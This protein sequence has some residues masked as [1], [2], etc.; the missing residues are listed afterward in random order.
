[1]FDLFR[2]FSSLLE[3]V[4]AIGVQ[5]L[6]GFFVPLVTA[7]VTAVTVVTAAP[8]RGNGTAR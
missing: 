5:L 6:A 8:R 1:M 4:Q 2:P 7:A 3:Q